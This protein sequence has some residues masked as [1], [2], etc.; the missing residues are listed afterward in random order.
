MKLRDERAKFFEEDNADLFEIV[1]PSTFGL[2]VTLVRRGD[3]LN[4]VVQANGFRL[5]GGLPLR[6]TEKN[7]DVAY[8]DG[9]NAR[10]DGL[11]LQRMFDRGKKNGVLGDL[12][13]DAATRKIGNDFVVLSRDAA[14]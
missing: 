4:V 11:G 9:S 3:G 10:R 5:R 7:G 8:P 14:G 2:L 12:N 1:F 6:G 13:D